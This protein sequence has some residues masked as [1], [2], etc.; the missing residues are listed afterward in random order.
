VVRVGVLTYLCYPGWLVI[1][2]CLGSRLL[3]VCDGV[4]SHGPGFVPCDTD[5]SLARLRLFERMK[6]VFCSAGML[7]NRLAPN[8]AGMLRWRFPS[9]LVRQHRFYF[10]GGLAMC[11]SLGRW[12]AKRCLGS[13]ELALFNGAFG[14]I[15]YNSSCVKAGVLVVLFLSAF[16]AGRML[17]TVQGRGGVRV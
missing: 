1:G 13:L 9:A 8:E 3:V 2:V 16:T 12:V 15:D 7:C 11:L 14:I 5:Y 17:V 4:V 10:G 6:R